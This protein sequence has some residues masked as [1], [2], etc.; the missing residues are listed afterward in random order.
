MAVELV[1]SMEVQ[2]ITREEMEE[3]KQVIGV[4]QGE[5]KG[6]MAEAAEVEQVGMVEAAVEAKVF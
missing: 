1:D 3:T 5:S 4:D 6:N 2:I